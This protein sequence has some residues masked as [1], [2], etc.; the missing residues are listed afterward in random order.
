MGNIDSGQRPRRILPEASKA[1]NRKPAGAPSQDTRRT[2]PTRSRPEQ[3]PL[4]TDTVQDTSPI[5]RL[6]K[7]QSTADGGSASNGRQLKRVRLTRENLAHFNTMAG[8]KA[9]DAGGSR[10]EGT[11]TTKTSST[12]SGFAMRIQENGVLLHRRSERPT[13]FHDIH[14]KLSRPCTPAPPTE[15]EFKQYKRRVGRAPNES[16]VLSTTHWMLL[17]QY[18]LEEEDNNDVDDDI[19]NEPY[20]SFMCQKFSNFPENVG[21]NNNC[22]APQPDFVEGLVREKFEPFP[23]QAVSGAFLYHDKPCTIALPHIAGEWKACEKGT[24][25][26]STQCA[27][28]GA[29]LVYARTQAL[30]YLGE[31]DPPGEARVLTFA[32]DG[33]TIHIFAHYAVHDA[34]GTL[35]Y[36]QVRVGTRILIT[37]YD[38]FKAGRQMLRNAQE[39]A[40]EQSEILRDKLV[41]HGNNPPNL[42]VTDVENE[43]EYHELSDDTSEEEATPP[44]EPM[45]PQRRKRKGS[46]TGSPRRK[47]GR[48]PKQKVY[49]PANSGT[50]RQGR[51][52]GRGRPPRRAG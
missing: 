24:E 12:A 25:K 7:R 26:A 36:H 3:P 18:D 42:V 46:A 43:E 11:A 14:A 38:D 9:K 32:T 15:L 8:T 13:N 52:R 2:R 50:A 17:K 51:N 45:V 48:P 34:N 10:T 35:Q 47:R 31:K 22:S 4:H 20:V 49:R 30:N 44:P 5:T 6:R 28:D 40:K 21:F 23:I 29:A 39:F 37:S 33:I 41:K 1:L 16:T 27:Y 19:D